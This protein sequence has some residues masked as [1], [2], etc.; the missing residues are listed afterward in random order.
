LAASADV[1]SRPRALTDA[2]PSDGTRH[3]ADS[4]E[5]DRDRR[6]IHAREINARL[7]DSYGAPPPQ[8]PA[9]PLRELITT[10]LS[11]HTSDVNSAR[12]FAA[13][14]QRFGSLDAVRRAAVEEIEA[15]IR[16]GGLART[17][18]P[19]IKRVLE[20]LHSERGRLDLDFLGELPVSE[21]RRYL[22]SLGGVGPKT[23]ACVLLFALGKPAIPVDTHVHRVSRRLGLIGPR[24]SAQQAQLLLEAIVPP[25]QAYNFHVNLIRHGRR[26]CRAQ[27]PLC[28]ACP[29]EDICP[30]VG[31]R[32][33]TLP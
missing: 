18:A 26:T 28:T 19:R 7:L 30:K 11:Q 29:L 14:L 22:T 15:A 5:S 27:R 33:S 24:A 10:M 16:S 1:E 17:K 8:A 6:S 13:L 9:D 31:V 2:Q 25:D 32:P 3:L 23:A 12:A 20:Q 21:A 4:L